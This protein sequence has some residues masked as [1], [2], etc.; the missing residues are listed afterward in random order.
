VQVKA[1]SHSG[2][3]QVRESEGHDEA[4]SRAVHESSSG[5]P[6]WRVEFSLAQHFR[7]GLNTMSCAMFYAMFYAVS[8]VP[9]DDG[10]RAGFRQPD[11]AS[12]R[13]TSGWRPPLTMGHRPAPDRREG[14][15]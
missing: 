7:E 1:V 4:T 9:N 15:A 2:K 14:S 8:A 5:G 13:W 3:H 10:R 11:D 12:A 6:A